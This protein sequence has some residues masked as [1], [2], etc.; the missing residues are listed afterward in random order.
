MSDCIF[1]RIIHKQLPAQIV[2][3][4]DFSVAFE[5]IHPK[6]PVHVL[7]IPR[8]HIVSLDT[9]REGDKQVL[10]HLL[11]VAQKLARERGIAE[12]GYRTVINTGPQAGQSVFHLHLHLLGGRSLG[13]P[14]G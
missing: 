5:D 8:V 12:T 4:D 3:E 10:G 14:P 13:W 11:L 7:V 6:A 2:H 1:C 9:M